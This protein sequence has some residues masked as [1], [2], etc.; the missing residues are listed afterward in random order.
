MVEKKKEKLN[1]IYD[2]FL[3]FFYFSNRCCVLNEGRIKG[4]FIILN[5]HP[6]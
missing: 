1:V 5:G 3:M 2:H 6:R 4:N